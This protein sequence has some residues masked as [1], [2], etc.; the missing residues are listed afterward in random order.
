MYY[1]INVSSR[2]VRR[3]R[4]RRL[5]P[6]FRR[7]ARAR[8]V[9]ARLWGIS[10]VLP[11]LPIRKLWSASSIPQSSRVY[12]H[13]DWPRAKGEGCSRNVLRSYL[14]TGAC[15]TNGSCAYVPWA[16]PSGCSTRRRSCSTPTFGRSARF[17]LNGPAAE[18][19]N[20]GALARGQSV[21][22]SGVDL[23]GAAVVR[24]LF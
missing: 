2:R 9:S 8:V 23:H 4:R 5:R 24:P 22:S 18:G 10:T 6:L 7:A 15:Y 13:H 21:P 12:L 14:A 3:R 19:P 16:R 20:G 17:W 11:L 1:G